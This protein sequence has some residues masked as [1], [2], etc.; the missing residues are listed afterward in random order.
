MGVS[1][2]TRRATQR[3]HRLGEIVAAYDDKSL[4]ALEALDVPVRIAG[5]VMT[6]RGQGKASFATLS[7]GD[8]RLQIYVRADD[9]GRSRTTASSTCSTSAI[10][11][12]WPAR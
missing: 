8:A 3:T 2:C 10:S 11:W 4:E 7:D 5:R 9:G 6:K 1:P 12:A